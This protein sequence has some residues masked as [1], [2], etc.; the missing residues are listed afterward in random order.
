MLKYR[1]LNCFGM[2]LKVVET[3]ELRIR[4]A[5]KFCFLVDSDPECFRKIHPKPKY[6][7]LLISNRTPVEG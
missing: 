5:E 2:E 7:I 4:E 1:Y 6:T 3:L